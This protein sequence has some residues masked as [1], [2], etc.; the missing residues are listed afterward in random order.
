MQEP[1]DKEHC[2]LCRK[3]SDRSHDYGCKES[4]ARALKVPDRHLEALDNFQVYTGRIM[5]RSREERRRQIIQVV[6]G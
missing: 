3:S 4:K 5:K 2:H 1:H 6:E